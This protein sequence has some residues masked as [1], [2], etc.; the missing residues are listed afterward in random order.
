MVGG[1]AF[2]PD[3]KLV[4]TA[5]FDNTVRLWDAATGEPKGVLKGTRNWVFCVA[6]SP[7]G[8]TLAS[9]SYDKTVR[10]WDV[11]EQEGDRQPDRPHRRRPR[12][13]PSAAT[14]RRWP[15]APATTPSACGTWPRRRKSTSCK[16]KAGGIRALAFSPDGKFLAS[17]A[18][19]KQ[20][21]KEGEPK[22][23]TVVMWDVAKGEEVRQ[24]Q[25][26]VQNRGFGQSADVLALAFSPTRP[27]HRHRRHGRHAARVGAGDGPP[28]Q[29]LLR[30][31]DG[32]HLPSPSRPT[33]SRSSP[34]ASTRAP[35]S[36][37][38][39]AAPIE[40][41][42][43]LGGHKGQVWFVAYSRDGKTMAT[44]GDDKTVRL[45]NSGGGLLRPV[46]EGRAGHMP[47]LAWS[48]DGKTVATADTDMKVQGVGRGHRPAEDDPRRAHAAGAR[49]RPV[50][51]RQ[52][53]GQL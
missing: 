41:R 8:K 31:P 38:S 24:F 48:A 39:T 43:A 50:A 10:L 17:A 46:V 7:D 19:E 23:A 42:V 18:E 9:G 12:R 49:R 13:S 5:G 28:A 52:D 4:A 11:A 20:E 14:A 34:A 22:G 16:G 47:N 2:S 26:T 53:A 30:P 25:M 37:R 32:R 51:R 40:S 15:P 45:W 21:V 1:V 3:G 44:G 29:Q 27:Q 6:F 36:G 35:A 33:A